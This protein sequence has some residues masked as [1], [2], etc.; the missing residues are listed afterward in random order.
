VTHRLGG[1]HRRTDRG[2]RVLRAEHPLPRVR[3]ELGFALSAASIILIASALYLLFRRK[4]W[5]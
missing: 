5:L 4:D 2:H 1:D 3:A